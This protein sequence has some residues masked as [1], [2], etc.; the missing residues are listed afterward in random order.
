MDSSDR[1]YILNFSIILAE[2]LSF[3]RI[4]F[5]N[6]ANTDPP[7]T[8]PPNTDWLLRPRG[9]DLIFSIIERYMLLFVMMY[10][11]INLWPFVFSNMYLR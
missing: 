8:D 7:N 4:T 5:R 3:L 10:S 2:T 1:D 6:L 9:Q 11:V